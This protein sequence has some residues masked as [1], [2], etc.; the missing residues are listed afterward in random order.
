MAGESSRSGQHRYEAYSESSDLLMAP[1]RAKG[2][3]L[4]HD[5]PSQEYSRPSSAMSSRRTSVSSDGGRSRDS[6][7]GPFASPFDDSRT[8]SR[9]GSSDDENINTQT[10]SERYNI[11]PS[12]GLLLYPEDIE[13]DDW[14]HNPDPKDKDREK[15][16]FFN[17][18]GLINMGGLALITIGV[19]VLFIG[20]PALYVILQVYCVRVLI[21]ER[22]FVRQKIAAS[23]SPC[24]NDP[25]CLTDKFPLLVN[26]RVG[27]I[28]PDTPDSVKTKTARDGGKLQLVVRSIL[29]AVVRYLLT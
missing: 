1:S 13:K 3:R 9:A 8:P 7:H 22:T 14:L 6:R 19:L 16:N 23:T 2:P 27:L 10:V 21:D 24:T 12:A 28:D 11:T 18:R 4:Y 20:Y 29:F 5:V 17:R 25:N 26:Q 15:F